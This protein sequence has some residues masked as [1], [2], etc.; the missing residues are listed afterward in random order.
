MH[1]ADDWVGR[2]SD[3][4]Q[5]F[6]VEHD[7][8][9]GEEVARRFPAF[10]VP[11]DAVAYL[12]P[13]GGFVRPE[14]AVAAQLDLAQRH[15][16]R[17]ALGERVTDIVRDGDGVAVE[18]DRQRLVADRVVLS[19][20]PWLP[21]FLD[22]TSLRA[23]FAIH[24]QV[25]HWFSLDAGGAGLLDPAR[26]PVYMW[27]FGG[28]AGDF[29]YGFP[30]IDGAA[31]GVKVATETCGEATTPDDVDREVP[32]DEA[33]AMFEHCVQ[34]RLRSVT[35]ARLRSAVCLYTVTPDHGFVV[36]A[37]PNIPGVTI[38]S[39]C[40]GHGFKHSAALGEAL[41]QRLAGERPRIDL[42]AFVLVRPAPTQR[43]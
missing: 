9:D 1:G 35:G 29:F 34:G 22:D 3:L 5:Q 2:T 40:S 14:S 20:G 12:E 31:G 42:D 25:L 39:P 33:S 8:L 17:L 10:A 30:A 11:P 32:D 26:C 15:G 36:D 18:T 6:D 7:V 41:A 38:V 23:H 43:P 16:A 4:A 28:A 37:H 21:G 19:V 13:G 24:R 27:S